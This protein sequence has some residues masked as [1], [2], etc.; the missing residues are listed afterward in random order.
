[1]R[2]TDSMPL[3]TGNLSASDLTWSIAITLSAVI[4]NLFAAILTFNRRS[5]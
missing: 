2:L 5:L 1:M 3:L 4:M